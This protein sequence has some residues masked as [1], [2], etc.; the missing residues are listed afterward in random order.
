MTDGL[1]T[2]NTMRER[3]NESR[4]KLWILLIAN[5]L[6]ATAIL[7]LFV[8]V[9]FMITMPFLSPSLTSQFTS[10]D[11]IETIFSTMIGAIVTATTLTVTIGQVVL[12]QE[13]GPLG[14]QRERMSNALDFRT[15]TKELTGETAP[16]DP[17]E[18]LGVLL[19][20]SEERARA[21]KTAVSNSSDEQ[22]RNEVDEFVDSLVENAQVVRNQLDGASFGTFEVLSA[23]LN[24]N[25]S[26]KM[27]Q[28]ER[29]ADEH[30]DS[31]DEDQ[32][33]TLDG[34]NTALTMY[35][36]AREHVKTLFF[37]WELINLSQLI[38]YISIPALVLCGVMVAGV[39][40][41]TFPGS[42]L[43][44]DNIAWVVGGAFAVTLLPFLLLT[45][46]ILRVVTV[47]KRTLAIEPLILRDSQQ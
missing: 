13:N 43:G 47:A 37:Q 19:D 45:S 8:F 22:L 14:D 2:G 20:E 23:A 32:R 40:P 12:S 35:G 7:A 28:T 3:A 26:V 24:F 9:A 17:S 42:T 4:L 16:A 25:Y 10:G 39:E 30:G 36:P 29:I 21:L 33:D 34:L 44:L 27:Y 1:D 11:A 31:L 5:R 6:V 41:Q 38:L 18:F 46:Y 15:F